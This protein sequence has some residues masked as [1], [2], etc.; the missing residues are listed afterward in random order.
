MDDL[1]LKGAFLKF[2]SEEDQ[3]EVLFYR[4][5]SKSN[6]YFFDM[7]SEKYVESLLL[8]HLNNGIWAG[9]ELVFIFS[10]EQLKNES[11]FSDLDK[12]IVAYLG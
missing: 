1:D 9:N 8:E 7:K 2:V 10:S 6:A 5:K 4:L 11:Y 3:P 12:S